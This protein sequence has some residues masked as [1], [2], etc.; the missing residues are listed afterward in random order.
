MLFALMV[1]P[2]MAYFAIPDVSLNMFFSLDSGTFLNLFHTE[3]ETISVKNII[4]NL[5]WGL[6][7]LGMPHI[8]IRF[9][10]IRSDDMIKKARNIAMVWVVLTLFSAVAIGIIGKVYLLSKGIVYSNQSQ[11]E[12]IFMEI[13]YNILSSGYLIGILLAAILAA[14]MS[15]GASQLLVTASAISNDFYKLLIRP[16]ADNKE[17][18]YVS[19]NA[20]LLVVIL[21]YSVALNPQSS[22]MNLVSYAWAGFGAAF[23][24]VIL[25][26]LFWR[27]LTLKGSIAGILSG[28][29]MVLC[30][31]NI[32]ILHS[33]GIY[34]ILP[35]FIVAFLITIIV[36]LLD[37]KPNK[38]VEVLFDNVLK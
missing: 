36:S 9:M 26:S 12:V 13:I 2:V 14:I 8:L 21:A 3:T 22:V 11:A 1:V 28:S 34:S 20:V 7:Y 16:N 5:A 17:L 38:D 10:A 25:L 32:Q 23:G 4:S 31:E 19:R 24:P 29:L 27:R 33:T 37:E 35:S 6:G 30:W 18:L 15:T